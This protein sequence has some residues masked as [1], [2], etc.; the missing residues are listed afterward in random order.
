MLFT[1][2]IL[3][4]TS[5]VS[6]VAFSNRSL[7]DDLILWP[8]AIERKKQYWRLITY[9]LIHA[10]FSHL[11]F[12]MITLFF[13]GRVMEPRINESLGEFG[14]VLFY[15]GGLIISILPTYLKN[16]HNSTYRSLGASGAVSAVLFA[17]ILYAPWAR[18][19]VYFLPVP[20]II[21]AVLYV[22]YSVYMDHQGRGNIN[23]SAHLW[24]AA[25]G[26]VFTVV[27]NPGVLSTFLE[28]LSQ[29]GM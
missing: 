7:I 10:D 16:R 25:Y 29:P 24:G 15:V 13:F 5:I 23:H 27:V 2:L 4:V 3:A 26:V 1:L 6:F 28:Q 9:G 11:L 20:A 19:Y 22:G 14:F 8:P 17:F 12:N 18:I 21:Y